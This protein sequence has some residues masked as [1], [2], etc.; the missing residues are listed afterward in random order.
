M[1]SGSSG[2]GDYKVEIYF[3]LI[4]RF[5]GLICDDDKLINVNRKKRKFRLE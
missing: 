5:L 2:L 1:Y 4:S 3:A